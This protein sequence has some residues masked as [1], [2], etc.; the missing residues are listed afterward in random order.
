MMGQFVV[1]G[2]TSTSDIAN[3]LAYEVYPN[4]ADDRLYVQLADENAEVYYVTIFN[5]HG[6][7]VMMLPQPQIKQGFDISALPPGAYAIQVMEKETKAV[8]TKKFVKL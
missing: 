8:S 2:T 5:T 7:A 3:P 1:K 6:K 4:P